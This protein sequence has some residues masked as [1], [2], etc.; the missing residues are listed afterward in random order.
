M[1]NEEGEKLILEMWKCLH[2]SCAEALMHVSKVLELQL[3]S[4]EGLQLK[5]KLL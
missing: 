5:S 3:A 2:S 4:I 1:D